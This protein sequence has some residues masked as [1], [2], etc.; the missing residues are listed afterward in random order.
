MHKNTSHLERLSRPP[1]SRLT[2]SGRLLWHLELNKKKADGQATYLRSYKFSR[3]FAY[4]CYVH[5][6]TSICDFGV[7]IPRPNSGIPKYS[8]GNARTS[9]N[10]RKLATTSSI[11]IS[12]LSSTSTGFWLGLLCRCFLI[13]PSL[14]MS[15]TSV[16]VPLPKKPR[17]QK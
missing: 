3:Y 13:D 17:S 12:S 11:I 7:C 9:I 2:F 4:V 1:K 14:A 6:I 8:P 16:F 15:K 5:E 10:L